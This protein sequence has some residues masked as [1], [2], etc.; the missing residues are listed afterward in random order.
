M[1]ISVITVGEIRKGALLLD[2]GQRRKMLLNWIQNEISTDFAGRILM[3]DLSVMEKW[4]EIQSTLE[5]TGKR[6]PTLDGLIAAT[7]AAHDLTVITR[8]ESDLKLSG[9]RVLNPW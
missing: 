6:L 9:V 3:L 4:A 1:F 5:K 8:N 2:E 7:A